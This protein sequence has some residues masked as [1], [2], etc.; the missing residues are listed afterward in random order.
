MRFPGARPSDVVTEGFVFGIFNEEANLNSVKKIDFTEILYWLVADRGAIV[1]PDSGLKSNGS[2]M[3]YQM[4]HRQISTDPCL[5]AISACRHMSK[6]PWAIGSAIDSWRTY[7]AGW[8]DFVDRLT[9]ESETGKKPF[10][11]DPF[12]AGWVLAANIPKYRMSEASREL[13]QGMMNLVLPEETCI[14]TFRGVPIAHNDIVQF[15]ATVALMMFSP[16]SRGV[17][18]PIIPGD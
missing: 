15:T 4:T 6:K 13:F 1:I 3:V 5:L 11:D 7:G 18:F 12:V 16:K 14:C 2:T 8:L 17:E 10:I 9:Y